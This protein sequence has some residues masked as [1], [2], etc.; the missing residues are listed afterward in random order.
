MMYYDSSSRSIV[1][2]FPCFLF[3]T[4][5]HSLTHFLHTATTYPPSLTPTHTTP[6]SLPPSLPHSLTG[7]QDRTRMT[8]SMQGSRRIFLLLTRTRRL[9]QLPGAA[10]MHAHTHARGSNTVIILTG[11]GRMCVCA[12]VCMCVCAY[13]CM[14][15][16]VYVCMCVCVYV[17]MRVCVYVRMCVCVYVCMC[18]CVYV[19]MHPTS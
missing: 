12:Y 3:P 16:C 11:T 18:A 9:P 10:C 4:H 6:Y 19:R 8:P 13:V 5:H 17:C 2:C 7:G 14:C 15:V 1:F